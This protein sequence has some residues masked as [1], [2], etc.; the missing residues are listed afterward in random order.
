MQIDASDGGDL[1]TE[2]CDHLVAVG[3]AQPP[4]CVPTWRRMQGHVTDFHPA[5][6]LAATDRAS[7]LA[8]GSVTCP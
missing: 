8:C 5:C 4:A 6:L 1:A 3:C 2:V 7:V